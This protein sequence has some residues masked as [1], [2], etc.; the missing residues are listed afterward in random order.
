MILCIVADA[1]YLVLPN[2]HSR[3]AGLYYFSDLP[4]TDPPKP[5]PT[6]PVHVLYKT[7]CGVPASVAKAGTG[8]LFLNGQEAIPLITALEEMGHKQPSKGTPL[9]TDNLTVHNI[10]KAQVRMKRSKAFDM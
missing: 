2:A 5:K 10:L 9:E 3:C 4:A 6:G 8:G 1:A 7:I